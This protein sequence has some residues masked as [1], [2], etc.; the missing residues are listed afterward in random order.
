MSWGRKAHGN[1]STIATWDWDANRAIDYDRPFQI[2]FTYNNGWVGLSIN[3]KTFRIEEGLPYGSDARIGLECRDWDDGGTV[4]FTNV[5]IE[6][7]PL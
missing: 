7:F 1:W 2:R 5:T 4:T 6:G 3:G